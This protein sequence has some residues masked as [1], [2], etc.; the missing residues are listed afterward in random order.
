MGKNKR[1][2]IFQNIRI[3]KKIKRTRL[4]NIEIWYRQKKDLWNFDKWFKQF[5]SRKFSKSIIK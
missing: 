5:N 1:K 4:T 3:R 2:L